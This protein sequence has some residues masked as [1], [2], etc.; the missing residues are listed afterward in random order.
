[1]PNDSPVFLG[2]AGLALV[3]TG[4]VPAVIDGV[5]ARSIRVDAARVQPDRTDGA[6]ADRI[7]PPRPVPARPVVSVEL[8]GLSET[9]VILK[10][11]SG[12]VLYRSEP[13]RNTTFVAR[14]A[15]LPVVTVRERAGSPVA[16]EPV[17]REEPGT[18]APAP[19]RRKLPMGCEG[20]VS[21][22]ASPSAARTPSLCLALA[23]LPMDDG[24]RGTLQ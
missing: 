24:S 20:A 13:R 18:G 9:A 17:K 2:V 7:A 6:K 12:R 15:E 16:E 1:M 8:V 10:D 3:L 19:E 4:A 23:D 5:G 11:E 22:L 21:A 14:G